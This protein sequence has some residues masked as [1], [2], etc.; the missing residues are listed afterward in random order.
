MRKSY[1]II[2]A[3]IVLLLTAMSVE[4]LEYKAIERNNGAYASADWA[5]TNGDVTTYAYLSVTETDDGTD[6]YFSSWAYDDM[7]YESYDTYGYMF[8]E[9]D[10][11]SID[12]KLNSASLSAVDIGI[13]KWYFDSDTGEYSYETGTMNIAADWVGIGDT[14]K[15]SYKYVS[16]DGEYVFRSTENSLSREATVTGLIN[17][18][19]F[20]SQSASMV[21]FKTAYM[22]MKK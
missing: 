21:K 7:T 14:S 13:E 16:K 2:F 15:G 10:V 17:G 20:E 5:E 19:N 12:K 8:T 6:I 22:H 1:T 9:D 18:N 4:A 11:F 3:L